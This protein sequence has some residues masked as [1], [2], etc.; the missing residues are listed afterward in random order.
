MVQRHQAIVDFLC[1]RE[2]TF[3]PGVVQLGAEPRGHVGGYRDAAM[4]SLRKEGQD[5]RVF[6]RKLA[7]VGADG[8][9]GQGRALEIAGRI[10]DADNPR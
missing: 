2:I 4:S 8:G 1:P 9:T 7:E 10:L 6:P 5:R 3:F